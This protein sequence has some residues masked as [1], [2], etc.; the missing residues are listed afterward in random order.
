[1]GRDHAPYLAAEKGEAGL[2][3]IGALLKHADPQGLFASGNLLP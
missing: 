2:A 3:A 1:V